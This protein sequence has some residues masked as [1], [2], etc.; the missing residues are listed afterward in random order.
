MTTNKFVDIGHMKVKVSSDKY[1]YYIQR[2]YNG[3]QWD[4]LAVDSKEDLAVLYQTIGRFLEDNP[5][6]LK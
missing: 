5:N 6:G 1:G 2:T 4:S 3:Y